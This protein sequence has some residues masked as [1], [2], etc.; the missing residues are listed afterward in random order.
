MKSEEATEIN[1]DSLSREELI[2]MFK[3]RGEVIE[4]LGN[5]LESFSHLILLIADQ[6]NRSKPKMWESAKF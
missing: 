2:E 3:H 1:Y 6:L 5:V 4:A